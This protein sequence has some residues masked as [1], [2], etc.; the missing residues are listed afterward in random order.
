MAIRGGV[1][2]FRP[3]RRA[4]LCAPGLARRS[5]A[6]PTVA[7]LAQRGLAAAPRLD[8]L[9]EQ[10]DV[11]RLAERRGQRGARGDAELADPAAA[12]ADDDR[13]LRVALDDDRRLDDEVAAAILPLLH[14]RRARVRQL[15]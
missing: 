2:L 13:L 5:R 1:I 3:P 15:L 12:P 9:H 7:E 4:A 8:D 14:R 10:H 6:V 11:D